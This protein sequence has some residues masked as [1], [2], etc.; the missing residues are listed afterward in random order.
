VTGREAAGE[1]ESRWGFG[2]R[3][4]I[5]SLPGL[6]GFTYRALVCNHVGADSTLNGTG[7]IRGSNLAGVGKIGRTKGYSLF[8]GGSVPGGEDVSRP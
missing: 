7:P 3:P 5:A 6:R 8:V 1:Q 4:V 2:R